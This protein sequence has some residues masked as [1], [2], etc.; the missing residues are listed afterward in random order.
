MPGSCGLCG[1]G[2]TCF[3]RWPPGVTLPAMQLVPHSSRPALTAGLACVAMG[4]FSLAGWW[5]KVPPFDRWLGSEEFMKA[6]SALG[7]ICAGGA[8]AL[9]VTPV[10]RRWECWWPAC[11]LDWS[12]CWA[13]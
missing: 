3:A 6:N 9:N 8:L 1:G 12:R 2:K 4:A 5:L 7:F 13:G 11:W 10:I